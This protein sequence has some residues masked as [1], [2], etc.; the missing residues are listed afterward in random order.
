MPANSNPTK[1]DYSIPM[2]RA[3][4]YSL[5]FVPPV[6]TLG[7]IYVQFWGIEPVSETIESMRTFSGGVALLVIMFGGIVL[8]ELIHGYTWRVFTNKP[9]ETIQFGMN[10]KAL[11]PYAHCTEPMDIL[12][13]RLGCVTPGVVVGLLPYGAGLITGNAALALFGLFFTFAASG[14]F[15]ILWTIR[16]VK[17][18]QLVEDHPKNAGCFVYKSS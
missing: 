12:A 7:W 5:V 10:W 6:V 9:K 15:I 13:Y 18:G 3:N 17:T 4:L 14:D 16:N 1:I 2:I 11:S 8:H